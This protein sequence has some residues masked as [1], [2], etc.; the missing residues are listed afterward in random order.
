M[1]TGS[2]TVLILG[3]GINGC[4]LARELALNGV[5]V[6]LVDIA[7]LASGATSGSSRLVHGG[8]RYLEYGEFDLVK[9][10]LAERGAAAAAGAA[11]RAPVAAVDSGRRIAWAESIGAIGRFFGWNWWPHPSAAAGRRA[12]VRAGLAFYDAYAHDPR[13]PKHQLV[14][15]PAAGHAA[16][17][18]GKISLAAVVLR[19]PGR[20]SRVLDQWRC[21]KT[22]AMLSERQGLDFRV[23]HVHRRPRS[24]GTTVE[25]SARR[26]DRR[27]TI[28]AHRAGRD[29]QCHRSL[30]R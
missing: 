10:S 11:I 19:R 22:P 23:M 24:R 18:L 1:T 30:G 13:W 21:W 15:S 8:L 16:G 4:A 14:A 27:G 17:R 28:A 12:L 25:I 3:A 2:Q 9:E 7:D 5:S 26:H 20:V 29:H 6:W